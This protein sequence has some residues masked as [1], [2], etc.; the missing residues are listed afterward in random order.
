MKKYISINS[1]SMRLLLGFVTLIV[2]TTLSAG[3]PA[4]WLTRS[5]LER[6]AWSQVDNAQSATQSL[7]EAEQNRLTNQLILFTER[8][9]LERL[10]REQ[11]VEELQ[12]YLRDFQSQSGLDML[13]LCSA[14]GLLLAGSD[15]F[16]ECLPKTGQG[17]TVLNGRPAVLTQQAVTDETTGLPQGTAVA[18]IWLEERFLQHLAAATGS[19]QSI[20]QPDGTRL[21]SSFAETGSTAGD[22]LATPVISCLTTAPITLLIGP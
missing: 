9:T 17:F 12:R 2:L 1:F 6:Q 10:I 5:Q 22:S 16:T 15:N 21:S 8:P 20:L 13:L 18:G 3:V 7:L 4:F 11:K 19:Q 14:D